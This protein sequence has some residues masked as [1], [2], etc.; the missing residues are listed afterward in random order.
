MSQ[1][2]EIQKQLKVHV[3]CTSIIQFVHILTQVIYNKIEK[4]YNSAYNC[5]LQ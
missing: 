5:R 2:M 1:F 3:Y 4:H